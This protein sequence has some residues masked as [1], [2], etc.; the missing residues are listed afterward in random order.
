MDSW[1]QRTQNRNKYIADSERKETK[2]VRAQASILICCLWCHPQPVQAVLSTVC[3]NVTFKCE[4]STD[5]CKKLSL[6]HHFAWKE[7]SNKSWPSDVISAV[8]YVWL[9]IHNGSGS[10]EYTEPHDEWDPEE[11]TRGGPEPLPVPAGVWRWWRFL[12]R[13]WQQQWQSQPSCPLWTAG[14]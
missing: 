9:N 5:R 8:F 11:E 1:Q 10:D 2:T 7:Y 14:L 3:K 12:Q 6:T 13:Q 4:A